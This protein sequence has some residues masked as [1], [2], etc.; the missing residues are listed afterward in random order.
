MCPRAP[1]NR[2]CPAAICPFGPVAAAHPSPQ[3]PTAPIGSRQFG[4]AYAPHK[5]APATSTD[6]G[7]T[8]AGLRDDTA[9]SQSFFNDAALGKVSVYNESNRNGDIINVRPTESI[10]AMRRI[11]EV[12]YLMS[13]CP[14]PL[15]DLGEIGIPPDG[16]DIDLCHNATLA[17]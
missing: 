5:K 15:Y 11:P 10:T 12:I 13:F 4:G 7:G 8:L 17:Q 6:T 3:Y 14:E 16:G 1:Q 9:S 2:V